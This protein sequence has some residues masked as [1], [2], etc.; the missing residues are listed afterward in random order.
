LSP[1]TRKY[2]ENLVSKRQGTPISLVGDAQDSFVE[3]ME[4]CQVSS[5][6]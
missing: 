2:L 6:E 5:Q 3:G 1:D 4:C